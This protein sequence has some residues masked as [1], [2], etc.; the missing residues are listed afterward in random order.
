MAGKEYKAKGRTVQKMSRNGLVEEDLGTGKK[1]KA[2]SAAKPEQRIGDRPMEEYEPGNAA[3]KDERQIRFNRMDEGAEESPIG[4]GGS[5]DAGR[6]RASGN[7]IK[8]ASEESSVR[9]APSFLEETEGGE[10]R[11]A[12]SEDGIKEGAPDSSR[13]KN[14]RY[15]SSLRTQR[16]G[17]SRKSSAETRRSAAEGARE[18]SDPLQEGS[19]KGKGKLRQKSV[20][21]QEEGAS[22]QTEEPGKDAGPLKDAG[23][24]GAGKQAAARR[25]SEKDKSTEGTA[26][27]PEKGR[28]MQQSGRMQDIRG[29]PASASAQTESSAGQIRHE[30]NKKQVTD[31]AKGEKKKESR[32]KE[33]VPEPEG[34]EGAKDELHAKQKKERLNQE[35][36]KSR[37][38]RLSFDDGNGMVKGSGA[39]FKSRAAGAA[40][41]AAGIT[42]SGAKKAA[43]AADFAAHAKV[44]EVEDENSGVQAAH[45]AERAAEGS[46][47]AV[48]SRKKR[49]SG[50]RAK[51]SRRKSEE[52]GASRLVFE[53]EEEKRT[54]KAAQVEADKK[55]TIKHFF[56][57]QR[58]RR[59]YAAAK[60]EEKVVHNVIKTQQTITQTAA[61]VVREAFVR[62]SKVFMILGLVGV[63]FLLISASLTSCTAIMQGS[64]SSVIGTTYPSTDEDIY[65]VENRYRELEA[66]LNAQINAM[67]TAHPEYDD[68]RYQIDEIS[69]NPYHLIS[70]FTT[71]YGQFTY[72]QVKDELEE[73]FREQYS[74]TTSGENNVTLTETKKVR[75][76][77]SLGQVVTSGYCSCELCCGQWA[78]SP[79]ASGAWPTGNHTI[80]VDA[81]DPFVPMGTHVI[82]NGVEYVVEDTGGFARYGVQ[83]DVYYDDHQTALNHG[84]QTWEA[85]LAD[86]NGSQEIEVTTT[87]TVNRY[88]VT[89]TNHSLDAV[90]QNRLTDDEKVRYRLYN[91]TYGHRDY[92]F[93]LNSLPTYGGS[94]GYTIP[95]EAL[96]DERFA[97]MI[98][99]A[100][101]H[102]GTPYV[103]GGYQPGAFDCSGFVSWVINHCGNGWDYGRLTAEGIRQVCAYVSPSD[104]KP[105]DII[106]FERTYDTVGASHVGIYVGNGMMIHC[107][108]PVQ[109]TT[110]NTDY[111]NSHFMQFGRLP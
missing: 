62:N 96:S 26:A 102:L 28:V 21:F 72:D 110:I 19:S 3:L 60:Q 87:Q 88:S 67:R 49:S 90:L 97:R 107:G 82:M 46:V 65:A 36:R 40:G 4:Q 73:I 14:A 23:S 34:L 33:T 11:G 89:L 39:G 57:K 24:G 103:W 85:Y 15:A 9:E 104:A 48:S 2:A 92:L 84:H 108:K 77:E 100:E 66:G 111:W 95:P 13:L 94:G 63:F 16:G 1:R 25:F 78:G 54:V 32:L 93:D 47:R 51:A 41:A 6:S 91:Q 59:M 70:Y 29:H 31:F 42:A 109:Y 86:S 83:F 38:S 27:E 98:A 35:Q 105:G 30:R 43:G 71:K 12:Y 17:D 8:A 22:G 74:L 20:L 81:S 44:S 106:F 56:R 79:T 68:F 80:A 75:V 52:A 69:H 7:R 37:G 53:T 18:A 10:E 58:Q 55:K 64:G 76:G 99:E 5:T 61:K 50:S 101:K 45:G